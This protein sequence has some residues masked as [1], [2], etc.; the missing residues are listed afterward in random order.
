MSDDQKILLEEQK[1]ALEQ[2]KFAFEQ[3]KDIRSR[4]WQE[5]A[6]INQRLNWLLTSQV[7]IGAAYVFLKQ[8]SAIAPTDP[9]SAK[10]S[11]A[12]KALAMTLPSFAITLCF[13]V[14]LGLLAG[15]CAQ[16]QISKKASPHVIGNSIVIKF[17]GRLVPLLL[18]TLMLVGWALVLFT[19]S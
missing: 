6:A 12:N 18:T 9:F 3:Q 4:W 15:H 17:L 19:R 7:F 11:I 5:E 10:V 14:F 1:L 8:Q 2:E 16:D 13:I